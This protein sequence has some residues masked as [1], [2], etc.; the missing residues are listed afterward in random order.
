MQKNVF[1][2]LREMIDNSKK[3][4]LNNFFIH[5][6]NSDEICPISQ[7]TMIEPVMLDCCHIFDKQN[8]ILWCKNNNSCPLCRKQFFV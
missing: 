3:S 5:L 6:C 2:Y 8:I 1:L 4:R 7:E